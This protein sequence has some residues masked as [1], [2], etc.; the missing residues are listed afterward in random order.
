MANSKYPSVNPVSALVLLFLSFIVAAG[1]TANAAAAAEKEGDGLKC[2]K[3][4]LDNG[5][6]VIFHVDHTLPNAGIN[7]WYRV[8]ARN[9]PAGRSGFAHLFEHLM[10]MGTQRVPASGFDDLMEARGG[11][12]N[13]STELDRTNYFSSG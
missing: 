4:T 2:E 1:P 6:T 7:L 12:S 9:E 10:F 5:M 8:G 13:A 11:S 3:Y